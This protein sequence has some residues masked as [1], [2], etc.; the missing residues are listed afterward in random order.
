MAGSGPFTVMTNIFVT[1]FSVKHVGKSPL[2]HT[3][4]P[5]TYETFQ[6]KERFM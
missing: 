4:L 5:L 1:E 6:T 2:R 3:N